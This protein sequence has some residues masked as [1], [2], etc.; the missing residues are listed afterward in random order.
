MPARVALLGFPG[1]EPDLLDRHMG[2]GTMPTFAELARR[3]QAFDLENRLDHLPD[4]VWP[5]I[6]TGRHG[7]ELGWYRLP[8]QLF[9]G[10]ASPR[11]VAADDFDLT[12]FWDHASQAGSR[13]A[14]VDVPYSG[15]S[16]NASGL[17]VHGWGTHDKP[18]GTGSD[19]DPTIIDRLLAKHGPHP[20][21]HIHAEHTRCDDHDGSVESLRGLR[22]GLLEGVDVKAGLFEDVLDQEDWDLFAGAFEE[23]HCAGHQFWHLQDPRSPWHDP[24]TPPDLKDAIRDVHARLDAALARMLESLGSE[25]PVLVAVSH[26]MHTAGGGWQLLPDFLVRVGYGSG[27]TA[28]GRV[29]S[30]LPGP[31][32]S[33]ARTVL[34]GRTRETLQRAAG[35]LPAPL[36]SSD[37]RAIALMNSPCGAIRLNVRGRDPFGAIDPGAE[38]DAACDELVE[39]LHAL[40]DESTGEP[41]VRQVVVARRRYGEELHPNIPDLLVQFETDAGPIETVTSARAGTISVPV[42][43]ASLPR[44]GDHTT[45]SRLFVAGPG[46]APRP[47]AREGNV[48]DIAPTILRLLDVDVPPTFDGRALDLGASAALGESAA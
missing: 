24:G 17:V 7:A 4:V 22:D 26:G 21:G 18:F 19:P 20:V 47:L 8:S 25:T 33:V 29:R 38:Y 32:K 16:P 35:S 39:E 48:V 23:A 30:R 36:G 3:G 42:R 41:A 12:A 9:S 15:P 27:S 2:D 34:R 45:H 31:V 10:E 5:E 14:I 40:V 1:M 37:T 44:S 6:F 11:H 46:I 13:I 43:T 28:A